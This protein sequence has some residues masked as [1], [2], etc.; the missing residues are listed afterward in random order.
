MTWLLLIPGLLASGKRSSHF[1]PA[2]TGQAGITE[3]QIATIYV[4][5]GRLVLRRRKP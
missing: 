2:M 4:R 3:T 1:A 5:K